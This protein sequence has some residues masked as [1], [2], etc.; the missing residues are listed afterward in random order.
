MEPE[1]ATPIIDFG[2]ITLPFSVTDLLS[3]SMGLIG[4]LAGF[5]LL[6]IAVAFTPRLISL[7]KGATGHGKSKS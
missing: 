5:I 7:I 4:L 6:G 3:S 1:P 2:G